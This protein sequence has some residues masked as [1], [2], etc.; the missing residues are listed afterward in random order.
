MMRL[1]TEALRISTSA[2]LRLVQACTC[3]DHL[4]RATCSY[5]THMSPV[6]DAGSICTAAHLKSVARLSLMSL[7]RKTRAQKNEEE[8]PENAAEAALARIVELEKE[9]DSKEVRVGLCLVAHIVPT[10]AAAYR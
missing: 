9:L 6:S 5:L 10:L 2:S 4:I 8:P 3:S 1:T 7:R